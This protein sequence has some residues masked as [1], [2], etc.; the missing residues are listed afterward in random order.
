[1]RREIVKLW[2]LTAYMVLLSAL[3]VVEAPAMRPPPPKPYPPQTWPVDEVK[4]YT[5]WRFVWSQARAHRTR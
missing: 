5:H 4:C 3:A 2:K 1:M